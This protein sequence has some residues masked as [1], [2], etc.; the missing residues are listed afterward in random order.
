MF[1]CVKKR[2]KLKTQLLRP[3]HL[4]PHSFTGFCV[5]LIQQT[6]G[7][8]SSVI[9]YKCFGCHLKTGLLLEEKNTNFLVNIL[10]SSCKCYIP[11]CCCI[12]MLPHFNH[13]RN[14][15]NLFYTSPQKAQRWIHLLFE[16]D[17]H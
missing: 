6:V 5:T 15:H 2:P 4:H 12:Q 1:L 9:V 8:I 13:W 16:E 3:H 17:T 11:R 14:D 7:Y 10:I